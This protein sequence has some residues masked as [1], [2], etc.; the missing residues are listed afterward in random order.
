MKR[1]VLAA[2]L[3]AAAASAFAADP[4]PGIAYYSNGRQEYL[5]FEQIQTLP[6]DTLRAKLQDISLHTEWIRSFAEAP[7]NNPQLYKDVVRET[8]E[9]AGEVE[10]ALRARQSEPERIAAVDE[11]KSAFEAL[12]AD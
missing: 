9:Q 3:L 4:A 8:I 11:F 5:S 2:L 1:T 10:D 12:K 7:F 6:L